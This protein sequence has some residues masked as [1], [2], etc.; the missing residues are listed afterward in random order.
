M[1]TTAS[2]AAA[3]TPAAFQSKVSRCSSTTTG[4]EGSE[5]GDLGAFAPRAPDAKITAVITDITSHARI[6]RVPFTTTRLRPAG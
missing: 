1:T 2:V 4:E 3:P 5:L 6:H